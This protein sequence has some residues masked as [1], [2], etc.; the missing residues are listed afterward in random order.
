MVEYE[1]K[2]VWRKFIEGDK[3]AFANI[4]NQHIATLYRYGT[5]L[6]DDDDLIKDVIQEVFIDLYL[7]RE[8]IKS[9]PE[10]LKYYLIL[11]F[12]RNLIKKLKQNRK[13]IEIHNFDL[14]F[15]PEYSIEDN[16]IENEE[17]ALLNQ[18]VSKVLKNLPGKQKEAIYLRYN[19]SME[20]FQIA[21]ILNITIDSARKQVYRAML[22]IR[23]QLGNKTLLL[24]MIQ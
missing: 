7:K 10:H 8:N 18:R 9:T 17:D 22:S 2:I 16:I 6:S 21:K 4:Y 11:A 20:Y 14:I 3:Q 13:K 12:K 5:K 24:W 1:H 23:K 19:E 15:E